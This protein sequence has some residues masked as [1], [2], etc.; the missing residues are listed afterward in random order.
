LPPADTPEQQFAPLPS[1]GAPYARQLELDPEDDDDADPDAD[2]EDDP[3]LD[4]D[5]DVPASGAL[6]EDDDVDEV[7][8]KAPVLVLDLL[9]LAVLVEDVPAEL[10]KDDDA[11]ASD[12]PS[13]MSLIPPRTWHPLVARSIEKSTR[14]IPRLY[15]YGVDAAREA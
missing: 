3:E 8:D 10:V 5:A 9:V 6:L 1:S 15:A 14:R 13:V 12:S 7:E 4:P 11:P 2:D